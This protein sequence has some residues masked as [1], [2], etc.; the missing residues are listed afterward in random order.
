MPKGSRA[1]KSP[2]DLEA[3]AQDEWNAERSP[4]DWVREQEL[5]QLLSCGVGALGVARRN[6]PGTRH[7]V[8]RSSP[9]GLLESGH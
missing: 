3:L 6:L 4:R 8:G 7:G 2:G 9:S 1:E 5:D